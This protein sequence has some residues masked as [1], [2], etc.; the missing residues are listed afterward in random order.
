MANKK[1]NEKEVSVKTSTSKQNK[2][3]KAYDK[4]FKVEKVKLFVIIVGR[5]QSDYY[6]NEFKKTEIACSFVVYGG[7]TATKDIYEVLG[8]G[9]TKKDIIF[10]LVKES[11]IDKLKEI[12]N[13][14]FKAS[15]AAKGIAFSIPLDSMAGVL[16]YRYLTN[17]KTNVVKTKEVKENGTK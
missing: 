14:R 1:T 9:E 13:Y 6:L 2:K 15:K 10:A 8:I 12:I 11:D 17:T 4:E 3:N 5:N 7:G 16:M